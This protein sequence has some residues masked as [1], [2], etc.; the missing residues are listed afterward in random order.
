MITIRK[1]FCKSKCKQE[2]NLKRLISNRKSCENKKLNKKKFIIP[3]TINKSDVIF[4]G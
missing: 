4:I 2:K 1:L 3:V